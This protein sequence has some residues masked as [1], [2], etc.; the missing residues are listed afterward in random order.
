MSEDNVILGI[1]Y[2]GFPRGCDDRRLPWSKESRTGNALET[3]YPYVC[4][5]ELNAIMNK[6]TASLDGCRIYTT[7][8]P[9]N[10][11][12]KL[13]VQ[14]RMREVVY[15]SDSQRDTDPNTASRR[16]FDVAGVNVWQ[17]KPAVRQVVIDFEDELAQ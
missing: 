11:C 4:H 1:G 14:S 6:N 7:L 8:F 10:E 5:A 13:I 9:C 17:Q 12:A 15:L 2:N 16:I 3:K